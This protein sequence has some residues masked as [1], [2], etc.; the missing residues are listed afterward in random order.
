MTNSE[1]RLECLKMALVHKD[2]STTTIIDRINGIEPDR[3]IIAN[4]WFNWIK[5]G[6]M[7]PASPLQ[8]DKAE[9]A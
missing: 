9:A 2:P 8:G 1:L 7:P 4:R 5:N 3:L 6:E